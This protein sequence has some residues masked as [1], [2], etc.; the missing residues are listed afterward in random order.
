MTHD[1]NLLDKLFQETT[2]YIAS[3]NIHQS[4]EICDV[5]RRSLQSQ[6]RVLTPA[7][8]P[9]CRHLPSALHAMAD[10]NLAAAIADVLPMLRWVRYDLYPREEIGEAFADGHAFASLIG[11]SG[12]HHEPDFDLGLFIIAPRTLYRDHHHA[13][14]ELYAPLTGP[15]GWRFLPDVNWQQL[16]ADVPVWNEPWAPH[17]TQ[18]GNLPFLCLFCWTRD[19]NI[20]ARVIT[21]AEGAIHE[22]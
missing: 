18:T 16:D 10:R 19:V 21:S 12:F 8:L 5:V 15:H 1:D 17:A 2:R 22:A 7:T 13:A 14:P 4:I 9:P 6:R 11:E 3:L 20:P